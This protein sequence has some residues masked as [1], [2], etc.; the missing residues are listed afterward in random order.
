MTTVTPP[1]A[2][3]IEEQ[4]SSSSV[5]DV[6]ATELLKLRA[7]L[8]TRLLALIAVLGP[9]AFAGLLKAQSGTPSDALF[10][11]WVHTSGF[12][13]SL[14]TLG[15]AGTWGV[16]IIAGALAGDLF[17]SEDRYGEKRPLHSGPQRPIR[18]PSRSRIHWYR[19]RSFPRTTV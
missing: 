7:Q 1:A 6:Y 17:A 8:T 5:G 4:R 3:P 2:R 12:A 10:G 11:A 14:V 16:P 19:P 13:V 15:F 9:F 18:W